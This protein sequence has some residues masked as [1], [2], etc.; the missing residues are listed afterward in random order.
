VGENHVRHDQSEWIG[1][2][3]VNLSRSV[4]DALDDAMQPSEHFG[5]SPSKE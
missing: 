1:E 4:Q 5:A 2:R 3:D